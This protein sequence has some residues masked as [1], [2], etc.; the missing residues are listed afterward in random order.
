MTA[1]PTSHHFT[2]VEFGRCCSLLVYIFL[3]FSRQ[4]N[5]FG[6]YEVIFRVSCTTL[7]NCCRSGYVCKGHFTQRRSNR[8][9][10]MVINLNNN[11]WI[12]HTMPY[13]TIPYHI[14]WNISNSH[15]SVIC[16]ARSM[17]FWMVVDLDN[18]NKLYHAIPCHIMP[19]HTVL[20]HK[21][22]SH[23]KYFKQP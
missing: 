12:Y 21:I 15:N 11:N 17:K 7:Q 9:F 5:F 19:C 3:I 8:P 10:C 20:Y 13:Y 23:T 14:I 2:I 4:I 16:Q 18:T 1:G 6:I 22:S